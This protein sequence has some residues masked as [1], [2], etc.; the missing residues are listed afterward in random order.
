MCTGKQSGHKDEG[1]VVWARA[2]GEERGRMGRSL[3]SYRK[4]QER[5]Q[6]LVGTGRPHGLV[7]SNLL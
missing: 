3:R 2:A 7:S 1:T 5:G 4:G 6:R